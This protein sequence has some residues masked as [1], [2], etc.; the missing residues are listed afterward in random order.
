MAH[1]NLS[2]QFNS[3]SATSEEVSAKIKNIY[4]DHNLVVDPHTAVGLVCAEKL[5]IKGAM[6]LACAHP[7]K[8]QKTVNQSISEDI[9]YDKN[10]KFDFDEKFDVLNNNYSIMREYILNH[11]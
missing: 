10:F 11:A 5:D 8:F 2:D 4:N 7:V 9:I 1:K 3:M 6:C